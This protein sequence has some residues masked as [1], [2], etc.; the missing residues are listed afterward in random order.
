MQCSKK[1]KFKNVNLTSWSW[2][3]SW[4]SECMVAIN[5]FRFWDQIIQNYS[6]IIESKIL[7][8]NRVLKSS[9]ASL[10]QR[11][12]YPK[13]QDQIKNLLT[14]LDQRKSHLTFHGSNKELF[15]VTRWMKVVIWYYG[16]MKESFGIIETYKLFFDFKSLNK[17]Q[18][19]TP[20]MFKV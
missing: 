6:D 14:L 19:K 18:I 9:L 11:K 20:L 16:S 13:L 8:R 17:S 3:W 4:T 10:N 12:N 1:R 7:W 2:S 5:V 15:D